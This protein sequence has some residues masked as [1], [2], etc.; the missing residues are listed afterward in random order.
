MT[1]E[2]VRTT[3]AEISAGRASAHDFTESVG[4]NVH[5]FYS[6][7]PYADAEAVVAAL[8]ELGVR[9]VRDGLAPDRPDQVAALERLRAAGITSTLLVGEPGQ[10]LDPLFELLTGPLEGAVSAVEGPNEYYASGDGWEDRVVP[11]Q[12][13]LQDRVLSTPGLVGLD[14]VGPSVS[15]PRL[16]GLSEH[17]N[18]HPYPGGGPPEAN[19]DEEVVGSLTTFGDVLPWATETGYH[20]AVEMPGTDHQ[21]AASDEEQAV[22][23]PRLLAAYFA[24]GVGRTFLYELWDQFPDPSLSDPEANYGLVEHDGTRKPQFLALARFLDQV[25]DEPGEPTQEPLRYR[26]QGAGGDEVHRLALR[27]GDG[28][29]DLLLW[30][31]VPAGEVEPL[32]VDV[33]LPCGARVSLGQPSRTAG[34]RALP[35]DE[36]CSS[37]LALED[38]IVVLRVA[39]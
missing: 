3:V 1:G 26:V 28:G 39:P 21:P 18:I 12:E 37:T 19:I 29:Y 27:R 23:L 31:P 30:R 25:A 6:D 38:D 15:E 34:V 32:R 13:R 5:L 14:V 4:V 35:L 22:Y 9:H 2:T 16:R 7:T 11:F 8:E 17:G 10:D 20:D 36:D 33:I 24:A